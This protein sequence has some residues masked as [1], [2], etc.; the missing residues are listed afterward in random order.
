MSKSAQ[1]FLVFGI[2]T[3]LAL[4]SCAVIWLL[5]R[6]A[7]QIGQ[8]IAT[9]MAIPQ[10]L[11][12]RAADLLPQ[13]TPTI[14]PSSVAVVKAMR[15]LARLETASYTIEKVV[16]AEQNQDQWATLFGDRLLLVAHGEV[17]AGVDLGKMQPTDVVATGDGRVYVVLPAPE[18]FFTNI[19]NKKTY[20]YDRDTGLLT[21]GNIHLESAARQAAQE[22][23]QAAASEDGILQLAQRNGERYLEQLILALGFQEVIF[24]TATPD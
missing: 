7:Q 9:N 13:N 21:N 1:N 22:Q 2:L 6:T 24:T 12:T 3:I 11:S 19:D 20:V 18:I 8:P 16:V 4:A 17:I 14:Y 10:L 23:I 5:Q 15:N